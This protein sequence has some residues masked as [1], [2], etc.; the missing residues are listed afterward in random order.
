MAGFAYVDDTDL[1]QT[2]RLAS[3]SIEDIVDELQGSLDVW[4]GTLRA[5]GGALDCD[6]P[7]KSYW[8]SIDYEWNKHGRW[9]Y[10]EF[11]DD[12]ELTMNN[13]KGDRTVAPHCHTNEAHRTLGVM[14]APDDNNEAQVTMM[15]KIA[16]KFGDSI[17]TGFIKGHDVMQALMTTARR[18]LNWSLPAVT[19]SET[20]CN[21]IMAP[22]IKNVLAKLQI[23]STIKRDVIY[24]PIH[25]QGMGLK[26]LYTQLG[27]M[28][29]SLL[30]QFYGSDTDLGRMIQNTMEC[31]TMELGTQ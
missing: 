16:S 1:I 25:L 24:G 3:D 2:K 21:H 14:L 20:E 8:Y 26:N 31:I 15:R 29:I 27:A 5:T 9:K 10:C 22:I 6:D 7:N 18:S 23:V 11:N 4:Q 19:I 17:R 12:L 30:L 28:H 13:D